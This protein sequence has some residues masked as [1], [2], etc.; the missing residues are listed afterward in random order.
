MKPVPVSKLLL[1]AGIVAVMT[2]A[3]WGQ[4]VPSE[5]SSH[6][7][8]VSKNSD[9]PPPMP[10]SFNLPANPVVKASNVG[11]LPGSLEVGSSGA[12]GYVIPLDVP[13]GP[14]GMQPTLAL[15]Y[16]S[17]GG[18][19]I[20]GMGWSVSGSLSAITRCGK[21][22]AVEGA[23]TGVHFLSGDTTETHADRFC[24]DGQKLASVSGDYGASNTEYRTESDSFTKIK[25]QDADSNGPESFMVWSKSG[26]ISEYTAQTASRHDINRQGVASTE[27]VKFIWLLTRQTDRSG[28]V[29]DYDYLIDEPEAA[30]TVADMGRGIEIVPLRISYSTFNPSTSDLD[31]RHRYVEFEYERCDGSPDAQC[32][33]PDPSFS[34]LSGVRVESRKRLQS[35]AMYGPRPAST[36][37]LSRYTF[38][39]DTGLVTG[40]SRL[41]SVRKCGYL[42]GCLKAKQFT[43]S[44]DVVD[45]QPVTVEDNFTLTLPDGVHQ[46]DSYATAMP[47][48]DFDG[49]GA[50]DF[51]YE[52]GGN[53]NQGH[54]RL[55][56]ANLPSNTIT[57]LKRKHLISDAAGYQD[58]PSNSNQWI[59]SLWASRPVDIDSD[60]QVELW[61]GVIPHHLANNPPGKMGDFF[62]WDID[63]NEFVIK[64]SNGSFDSSHTGNGGIDFTDFNG[65][66]LLD[67]TV[68]SSVGNFVFANDGSKLIPSQGL[69]LN[70][71]T[72]G[73]RSSRVDIDGDGKTDYLSGS[74]QANCQGN[75]LTL[76]RSADNGTL[77][78]SSNSDGKYP[79]APPTLGD[80]PDS[81]WNEDQERTKEELYFG[82]FNGDGLDDA[83]LVAWEGN[84]K[85]PHPHI[86]IRWNTGNGFGPAFEFAELPVW[87]S[88]WKYRDKGLRIADM[89]SDG[90]QDFV[91]FHTMSSSTP[92]GANYQGI[93]TL[94]ANGAR[95]SLIGEANRMHG[96][97]INGTPLVGDWR[98]SQ[99]G[100]FNGDGR[101]DIVTFRGDGLSEKKLNVLENHLDPVSIG[102][103][104]SDLLFEV[105]DE[106]TNWPSERVLYSTYWGNWKREAGRFSNPLYCAYPQACIRPGLTVVRQVESRAHLLD[107]TP[108]DIDSKARVIEYSYER[109]RTDVRGRGFLG[110]ELTRM[111]DKE[112]AT[113]TATTYHHE[114]IDGKYYKAMQPARTRTAVVIDVAD[115]VNGPA[116][117]RVV[118]TKHEY[119][120]KTLNDGKTHVIRPTT[121]ATQEWEEEVIVQW[122]ALDPTIELDG[123]H[124]YDFDESILHPFA[125]APRYSESEVT[126]FDDD[127]G[128]VKTQHRKTRDGVEEW[129]E[130]T[131]QNDAENWL[132]GMTDTVSVT[133]AE[134]DA[135]SPA[136]TRHIEYD[137]DDAG[138]P[139]HIYV[140]KNNPNPDLPVTTTI[141]YTTNGS[142]ALVR[143]E[144]MVDGVMRSREVDFKYDQLFPG[145]P[146]E[147]IFA[148]QIW[149]PSNGG[150]Y[151]P[152]A[153]NAIHPT[154]GVPVAALDVN[155]VQTSAIYD[156]LGRPVE[157]RSPGTKPVLLTYEPRADAAGG[158]NGV[159]VTSSQETSP[160]FQWSQGQDR[161]RLQRQ[162]TTRS[163]QSAL[164][165]RCGHGFQHQPLRQPRSP[166]RTLGRRR[167][168]G[169]ALPT[170]LLRNPRQ[171]WRRQSKL[172]RC[173]S[174][175]A[176]RRKRQ[177]GARRAFRR[178]PLRLRSVRCVE[179]DHR[180][181]RQ[182]HAD[183]LRQPGPA[184]AARR[185]RS[186]C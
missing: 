108:S 15:S 76:S 63:S 42:G 4:P 97:W 125:D 160:G 27:T 154:L 170:R 161:L 168:P 162:G 80:L 119:E 93:T 115:R 50:D 2:M 137:Y 98:F 101:I 171:R 96:E 8:P 90:R 106:F 25:S 178:K 11:Y 46:Y 57:P 118:D 62:H 120:V 112:R 107:P 17:S 181:R 16:S 44:E 123:F 66:A 24:L 48:A 183:G 95:T 81:E 176:H 89:D 56:E 179:A 174:R 3:A 32:S 88:M 139:S 5:S 69:Q 110:F 172:H 114:L 51:I 87:P 159:H 155:G 109:P 22:F 14:A 103:S 23:Q 40:R 39:Y 143:Q 13:P 156:D 167:H 173:R 6:G 83:A 38:T 52:Y 140:E 43:W 41:I 135:S 37:L 26:T 33:R 113:E 29:I 142:P 10:V 84:T 61:A 64:T 169:A 175:R 146:D 165:G 147:K 124:I 72:L 128:N 152:S 151:S 71:T 157:A 73:C 86:N 182:H 145:A 100:D 164:L 78:N 133:R 177:Q 144:A 65:D 49:D 18:N 131:Y 121:S 53:G 158:F 186:R 79:F 75:E 185:P 180:R 102:T 104:G 166:A 116:W 12:S 136:D 77:A 126:Y 28:N 130:Y 122:G 59:R 184:H 55:G 58:D 36:E 92:W 148:S 70:T 7:F 99:L 85:Q 74:P 153:W 91:I 1:S 19:G 30:G 45:F 134:P 150:L 132:L 60:G 31:D 67:A 54:I 68:S 149:A 117:V 163:G 82:D 20:M 47:P 138:R 35:I 141:E 9:L 127:F 94:Y 105:S 111:W 21:T 34:W 129:V